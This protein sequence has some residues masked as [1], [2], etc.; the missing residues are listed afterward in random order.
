MPGHVHFC[1]EQQKQAKFLWHGADYSGSMSKNSLCV[2]CMSMTYLLK[3]F[4][5]LFFFSFSAARQYEERRA[6]V[7]GIRENASEHRRDCVSATV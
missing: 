4:F 6:P 5:C 7:L 1:S 3:M 2:C